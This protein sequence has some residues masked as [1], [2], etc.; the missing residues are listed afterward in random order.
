MQFCTHWGCSMSNKENK[1][2]WLLPLIA[3]LLTIA[4]GL[5]F[6]F[7]GGTEDEQYLD[8]QTTPFVPASSPFATGTDS[9]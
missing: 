2:I 8:Y 4:F 9:R 6:R 7:M 1:K 3:I 5:F